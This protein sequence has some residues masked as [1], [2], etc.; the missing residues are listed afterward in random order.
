MPIYFATSRKNSV[1]LSG[2]TH[3][4]SDELKKKRQDEIK[5]KNRRMR[6][7][8]SSS[9]H[10]VEEPQS[11][12]DRN[13]NIVPHY[14]AYDNEKRKLMFALTSHQIQRAKSLRD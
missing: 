10:Q 5:R 12:I 14:K 6:S 7:S 13:M 4:L 11:I 2:T 9:P 1:R 8:L 3:F